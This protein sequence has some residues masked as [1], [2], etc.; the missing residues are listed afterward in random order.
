MC[1]LIACGSVSA[2]DSYCCSL[3]ILRADQQLERVADQHTR[4]VLRCQLRTT[5]PLVLH[6]NLEV[7]ERTLCVSATIF[8]YHNELLHHRL[9]HDSS[10]LEPLLETLLGVPHGL[11]PCVYAVNH[12]VE[13]YS[14]GQAAENNANTPTTSD[15]VPCAEGDCWM[16]YLA[17]G[18]GMTDALLDTNM[19]PSPLH[20]DGHDRFMDSIQPS[21][22]DVLF[23]E[24]SYGLLVDIPTG[25]QAEQAP[26]SATSS[27]S[28][29]T[30]NPADQPH[31]T[32]T[33]TDLHQ[34]DDEPGDRIVVK[35]SEVN[36]DEAVL[37]ERQDSR[38][39]RC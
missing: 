27:G 34:Q 23:D 6:A 38:K 7:A 8:R 26:S 14:H 19:E 30:A 29:S 22:F 11:S 3:G 4:G 17:D 12:L 16:P 21:S 24:A 35:R 33:D 2:R 36:G 39:A 32:L 10:C 31:Q 5:G 37:P 13:Q 15:V 25:G 18:Y 20:P 9:I 1:R 28:P